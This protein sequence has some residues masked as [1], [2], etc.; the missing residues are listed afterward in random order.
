[1][2]KSLLNTDEEPLPEKYPNTEEISLDQPIKDESINSRNIFEIPEDAQFF[3]KPVQTQTENSERIF[4]VET[5]ATEN[6]DNNLPIIENLAAPQETNFISTE[7]EKA[8]TPI[9]E[10]KNTFD[11][12]NAEPKLAE[13]SEPAI[14]QSNYTPET[15][16]ETI[17]NSG[18]AYTAAIVLFGAIVFMMVLGWFIGQLIG[19]PTAGIVGGIIIGALIGF[20]QFFRITSSIFK[21]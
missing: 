14:F 8:E 2:I 9:I 18:M 17:R 19:N 13:N 4:E 20:I 6:S 11:S 15:P 12:E 10:P 7:P 5:S 21:K 1:M 3:A 16:D